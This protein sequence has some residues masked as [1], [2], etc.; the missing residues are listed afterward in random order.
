MS[1]GYGLGG[2]SIVNKQPKD[3]EHGDF[4]WSL[5]FGAPL[6]KTQAIKLVY[7]RN[8]TTKDV[9]ANTNTIGISWSK[10]F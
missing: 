2:Q 10:L 7:I 5:S 6:S 4:L 9:G 8:E 3:D 1:G